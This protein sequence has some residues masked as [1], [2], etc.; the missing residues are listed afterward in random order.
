MALCHLLTS[1][2]FFLEAHL[3]SFSVLQLHGYIFIACLLHLT[4]RNM[5]KTSRILG[6]LLQCKPKVNFENQLWKWMDYFHKLLSVLQSM[7]LISRIV[8]YFCIHFIK[9][10][11]FF[12]FKPQGKSKFWRKPISKK[13]EI[14]CHFFLILEG[15]WICGYMWTLSWLPFTNISRMTTW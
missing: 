1:N 2:Q 11:A 12:F 13:H 15:L 6:T 4:V 8:A 3:W 14:S 10:K 9:T 7:A 5:Q